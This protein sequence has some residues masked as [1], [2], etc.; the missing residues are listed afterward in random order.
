MPSKA[1]NAR[2]SGPKAKR[3]RRRTATT[4]AESTS[5]E[6]VEEMTGAEESAPKKR[7]AAHRVTAVRDTSGPRGR[8]LLGSSVRRKDI[9]VFLRQ[10]V[11]L[12]E[13]GTPLLKSLKTLSRRLESRGIRNMVQDIAE[14]VE[15]GNPL[16]QAFERHPHEYFDTVFVALV[17]A[18]EASGTLV[19]TLR[20]QAEYYERREMLR[21]RVISALVYPVVLVA[22]CITVLFIM[23]KF[24]V[25]AFK[26]I[27]SEGG[28]EVTLPAFT[29]G[30]I[31]VLEFLTSW[32]MLI[33]IGVII[34]L[35]ILYLLWQRSPVNRLLADR[36]KLRLPLVGRISQK[37]AV[38]QMASSL[39]ML[40]RSG[41][42]MMVTLD[43]T[44]N[45]IHNQAV[46]QV[47]QR[48][49]SSVEQGSGI[50]DPL[51]AEPKVIPP[52]VT[53]MLVTGEEA[54]Q[55]DQVAEHIAQT[56]EEEVQL[57]INTLTDLLPVFLVI[58]LGAAVM[59]L[60][61]GFFLPLISSIDQLTS[62]A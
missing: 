46:A 13:A 20:R 62:A 41:L 54:G 11:M 23:A 45:A 31:S 51:R 37:Y 43:L 3:V 32:P 25:P 47:L 7:A 6:L 21:R 24:V 36:I 33:V 52:V 16:W 9:T 26:E 56:Y 48:V 35:F 14:Q 4:A 42:S 29:Q 50:E 17:K 19:S 1:D 2:E 53:D 30:L 27:F 5:A 34:G 8:S 38:A 10:L 49:R 39:S 58:V 44:R 22:L 60:V 59:M 15:N 12:L 28:L 18:S 55:L 57:D 61:L 40:L